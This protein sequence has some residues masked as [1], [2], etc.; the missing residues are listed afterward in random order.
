MHVDKKMA[1][2]NEHSVPYGHRADLVRLAPRSAPKQ[3]RRV[4]PTRCLRATL[5]FSRPRPRPMCPGWI[6]IRAES[7]TPLRLRAQEADTILS[8]SVVL[9]DGS[10]SRISEGEPCE[11]QECFSNRS[12][13]QS[14]HLADQGRV[15][16]V[17]V[18]CSPFQQ[19]GGQKLFS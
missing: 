16:S 12:S 7:A 11:R 13:G 4:S 8:I 18:E 19:A 5:L 9:G 15:N 17:D 6:S 14:L 1:A 2:K 3:E 10:G